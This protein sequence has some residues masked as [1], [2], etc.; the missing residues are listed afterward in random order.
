MGSIGLI[1][2]LTVLERAAGGQS[3][4]DKAALRSLYDKLRRL[5]DGLPR[6]ESTEL[7]TLPCWQGALRDTWLPAG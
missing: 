5:D 3:L 4:P 6:L 1:G 2:T 7:L